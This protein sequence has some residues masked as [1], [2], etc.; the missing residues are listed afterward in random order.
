MEYIVL[1]IALYLGVMGQEFV[2]GV[3]FEESKCRIEGLN[4]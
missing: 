4:A 2:K 3:V 1:V